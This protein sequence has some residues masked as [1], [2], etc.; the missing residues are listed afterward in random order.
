MEQRAPF[1]L[2][3]DEFNQE[4]PEDYFPECGMSA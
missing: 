2:V 3:F 1:D 4:V